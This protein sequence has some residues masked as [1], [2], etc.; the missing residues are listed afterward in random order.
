MSD[1]LSHCHGFIYIFQTLIS[2]VCYHVVLYIH[3]HQHMSWLGIDP[4]TLLFLISTT[5]PLDF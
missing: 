1:Y 3:F 5:R 2:A 4:I